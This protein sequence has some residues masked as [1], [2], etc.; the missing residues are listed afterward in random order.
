MVVNLSE[1][2]Y[3]ILRILQE[4]TR[5]SISDISRELGLSRVTVR[6]RIQNIP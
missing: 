6:Q 1:A 5:A 3:E 2:D 4:N